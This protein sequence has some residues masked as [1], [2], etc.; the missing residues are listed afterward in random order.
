ML[1]HWKQ[2][3]GKTY[4]TEDKKFHRKTKKTRETKKTKIP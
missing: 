2:K 1:V 3:W 4:Q